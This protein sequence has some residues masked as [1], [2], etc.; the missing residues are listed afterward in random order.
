MAPTFRRS[1]LTAI[2]IASAWLSTHSLASCGFENGDDTFT[3][4]NLVEAGMNGG[5][6]QIAGPVERIA[7][8]KEIETSTAIHPIKMSV[9]FG[10]QQVRSSPDLIAD[11]PQEALSRLFMLP[12]AHYSDP[13]LSWKFEVAPAGIGFLDSVALGPNTRETFS[14]ARRERSWTRATCSAS[15][16]IEPEEKL[17][18]GIQRSR[19]RLRTT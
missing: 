4:L 6:I 8:F 11:T 2:V 10:L 9:Y 15:G 7:Q 13:K 19:T 5:W 18:R 14:S 16:W 1:F 3:E 12:G 17:P